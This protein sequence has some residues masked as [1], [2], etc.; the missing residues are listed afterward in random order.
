MG[1]SIA[2]RGDDEVFTTSSPLQRV[3]QDIVVENINQAFWWDKLGPS[4]ASLLETSEYSGQEQLYY[5]RWFY[6]NILPALGPRPV[7]GK[8]N[9]PA[10][11]THDGSCLE[12]SLNWKQTEAKQTIRFSFEP[13]TEQ[14]GT[15][16]DPLNQR[17]AGIHLT[18]LANHI[19]DADLG[20]FQALRAAMS[21]PHESA[22]EIIA[23]NPPGS[24][25]STTWLACDLERGGGIVAKSYYLPHLKAV[26]TG[27]PTKSIVFDA[28]RACN[29][30]FGVY[31][32]GISPINE[33]LE[34]FKQG[35]APMVVLLSNDCVPD[36]QSSRLKVYVFSGANTLSHARDMF[37]L[38]GRLS[39]TATEEG[40]RAIEDFWCHLFGLDQNEPASADQVVLPDAAH[41]ICVYEVRPTPGPGDAPNIEVKLHLPS[42][43]M[44]KTDAERSELLSAWFERHGAHGL[45][46]RYKQDLELAFP[47]SNSGRDRATH[48]WISVTW[49]EKSGLYMTMYYSPEIPKFHFR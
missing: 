18:R 4:F 38:G 33:Y 9:Y 10:W 11:I 49:T 26:H 8:S 1:P 20:R 41:F 36:S 47:R 12:F 43:H 39:G 27:I 19:P 44:D 29:G 25:L 17:A 35:P 15:N 31:D 42:W 40:L 45:A 6:E 7:D 32:S 37:N 5:L 24:P 21:V 28:M 34:S 16:A 48:T 22:D 30:A 13:V 46:S 3:S 23:R 14:A 2:S